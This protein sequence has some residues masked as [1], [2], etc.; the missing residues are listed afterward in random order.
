MKNYPNY[1]ELYQEAMCEG[2]GSKK[3]DKDSEIY[4]NCLE[5]KEQEVL[6][7]GI[8][9]QKAAQ[10]K[11]CVKRFWIQKTWTREF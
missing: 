8:L 1:G 11:S 10:E 9:D 4:I 3:L 7:Q 2:P 6:N 5:S